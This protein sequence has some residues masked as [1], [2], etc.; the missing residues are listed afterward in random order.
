MR[1]RLQCRCFAAAIATTGFAISLSAQTA[2]SS[3]PDWSS[4]LRQAAADQVAKQVD[5]IR[6][7]AK[8]PPLRRVEPSL[9]EIEL[10]CTAAL[11]GREVHD[12]AFGN[13]GTY[14]TRD[15]SAE[16]EVLR[17]AALGT[18]ACQSPEQCRERDTRRRVYPD[19]WQRYS[20]IVERNV[21]SAPND[22]VYT[23]GVSRRPS[24]LMEF[25]APL[26]FDNPFNATEWKKQVVP[27]C[28]NRAH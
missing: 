15:L 20:V 6:A 5:A 4:K 12:P 8:L 18:A 13:L 17:T 24:V 2:E 1:W 19:K 21:G 9:E 27:E 25:F 16:T 7:S 22:L 3:G 23:V 14:V 10:V 26:G 28:R 11:T